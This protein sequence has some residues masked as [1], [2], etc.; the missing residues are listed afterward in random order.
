MQ[1][2][3]M[4]ESDNFCFWISKQAAFC[5]WT[6]RKCSRKAG[7]TRHFPPASHGSHVFLS[8]THG[9]FRQLEIFHFDYN[10]FFSFCAKNKSFSENILC[11]MYG[12][13]PGLRAHASLC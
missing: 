7:N 6:R 4:G 2:G 13:L 1:A 9:H 12:L 5:F 11:T 8:R 3:T 10:T